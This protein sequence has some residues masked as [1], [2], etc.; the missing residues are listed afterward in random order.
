MSE[1][2]ERRAETEAVRRYLTALE[3]HRQAGDQDRLRQ[4]HSVI[5]AAL[6]N[7]QL[8][9]VDRLRLIQRRRDIEANLEA[10]AEADRLPELEAMFCKVAVSWCQRTGVTAG[11]LREVGVPAG[12]ITRAGL[13]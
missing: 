12:L 11:A 13:T 4:R 1:R 6:S 10:A 2:S 7:G 5:L 8:G 9:P 3:R